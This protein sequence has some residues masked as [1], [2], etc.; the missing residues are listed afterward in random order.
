MKVLNLQPV[1]HP[2]QNE[3]ET[4]S[5]EYGRLIPETVLD[6]KALAAF[7]VMANGS[8]VW[9]SQHEEWE[10]EVSL[11]GLKFDDQGLATTCVVV[12]GDE[13]DFYWNL[14]SV[15]ILFW[16][17]FDT[18]NEPVPMWKVVSSSGLKYCA[19]NQSNLI[20]HPIVFE[21]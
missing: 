13:F 12:N 8:N 17:S 20:P 5:P 16:V 15:E 4:Y 14:P 11:D 7:C 18:Q 2:E 1:T 10:I 19:N 6:K 21:V 9:T 3:V